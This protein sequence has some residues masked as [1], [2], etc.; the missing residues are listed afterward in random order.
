L[1]GLAA[2]LASPTAEEPDGKDRTKGSSSPR[3]GKVLACGTCYRLGTVQRDPPRL[4]GEASRVREPGEGPKGSSSPRR[5]KVLAGR[6]P[7]KGTLLASVGKVLACGSH[8]GDPQ[9]DPPRL[10]GER[11]WRGRPF[12]AGTLRCVAGPKRSPRQRV[13]A[14]RYRIL[15]APICPSAGQRPEEA[16]VI[17]VRC[18]GSCGRACSFQVSGTSYCSGEGSCVSLTSQGLPRPRARGSSRTVRPEAAYGLR[19][20]RW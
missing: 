7:S 2:H 9:R 8:N 19:H 17:S 16:L 12:D 18:E 4:G 11:F 15:V 14:K 1:L 6:R 3:R 20:C 13:A 5:G 10:G